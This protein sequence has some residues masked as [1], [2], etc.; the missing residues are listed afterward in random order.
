MA[1]KRVETGLDGAVEDVNQLVEAWEGDAGAG[2]PMK[3]TEIESATD[4]ALDVRQK[5]AST[6]LIARFRDYLNNVVLGITKTALTFGLDITLGA[7]MTVD[8]VDVGSHTHTGAAGHGPQIPTGGLAD[9]AVTAGKVKDNETLPVSVSGNAATATDADTLDGS[10]AAD[11]AVATKGVTNG[12][13]HDHAGGDGAQI[14][15]TGLSN[16]G[17]NTHAQVDTHV[18]A[19]SAHGSS[20][21]VVGQTT[22]NTHTALTTAH[23]SS[24]AVVGQTT[25]NTHKTSTDHDGR[26]FTETESDARFAPTAKGVTN[27]N[28]HDHVGGDGA[29]IGAGGLANGAVDTT[30]R[31]ANDIVDDTKV[32]NRVPALTRR[33]GGSATDWNTSGTNNYTPTAVRMQAGSGVVTIQDGVGT[34]STDVTFPVAFSQKPLIFLTMDYAAT[35]IENWGHGGISTTGFT[36][37]MWRAGTTGEVTLGFHW[38]AIGPE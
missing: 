14:N 21:A 32:G 20:G 19:T 7:G 12:D 9:D 30:A 36:V 4:Y 38:L 8:G 23:G 18:A 2:E 17:T 1:F 24:G 15:H 31:L 28:S 25:L 16:I 22:L 26:Y 27:G 13:S 29:A 35:A 11:F 3:L 34:R 6:G 37:T 5:D 33:Q 10:H